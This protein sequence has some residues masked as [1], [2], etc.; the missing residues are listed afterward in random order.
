LIS[1]Q[2]AREITDLTVCRALFAAWVFCYH[3]D[4][5]LGLS[6]FLGPFAG[7]VQRGYLG[8]DGFFLLS[9]LILA[10]NHGEFSP[11]APGRFGPKAGHF[12]NRRLARIYP[13]HAATLCHLAGFVLFARTL[14]IFPREAGRFGLVP[15]VEN[16]C[17]IQG[18]GFA[19]AGSWNYPSWSIST[20]WAGYL[21]FPALWR[22]LCW[23]EA[24]VAGP[25]VLV[26]FL[27]L[28]LLVSWHHQSLNFGFSQGLLRFFPEFLIGMG[29]ARVLPLGAGFVSA[30][31]LAL[32]GLV[33]VAAGA[34]A[35]RDF[36]AL[37]GLWL[38]LTAFAAQNDAGWQP[39]LGRPALL[40]AFGRLSYAF[41]MSFAVAELLLVNLFRQCG[42]VPAGRP[43][44]FA[45]GM[46]AVTLA[47]AL[48]LHLA[49]ERPARRRAAVSEGKGGLLFVNKS[50][51]T[52]L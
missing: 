21:L 25:L 1:P 48:A 12:L 28:G 27:V 41:Y 8:V 32:A 40:F 38:L 20:E 26:G 46:F 10:R 29:T 18:W 30:R 24:V 2:A 5:Y 51:K 45:S 34:G 36:V 15:L 14:D 52:T 17:L 3:V 9:G 39:L 43:F 47:L 50:S 4:L 23:C 31:K 19:T 6:H 13:V 16:L 33:L 49:V 35:G 7:W 42:W 37:V 44:L 22:A 11:R